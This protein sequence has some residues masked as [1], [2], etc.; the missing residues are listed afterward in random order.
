MDIHSKFTNNL[1]HEL[2]T[3]LS[4]VYPYLQ[5]CWQRSQNLTDTQ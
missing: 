1:S 5:R 2:R 3:P 4:M